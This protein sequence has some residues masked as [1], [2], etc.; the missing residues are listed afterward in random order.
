[1]LGKRCSALGGVAQTY[2]ASPLLAG[3]H[4]EVRLT[5]SSPKYFLSLLTKMRLRPAFS[6]LEGRQARDGK[7]P[8]SSAEC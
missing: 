2:S 3:L 6:S 8:A 7:R 1:M 5:G 4:T